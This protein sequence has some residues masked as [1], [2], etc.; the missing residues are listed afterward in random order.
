M[1]RLPTESLAKLGNASEDGQHLEQMEG[2][3]RRCR[4]ECLQM[5]PIVHHSNGNDFV[6]TSLPNGDYH[7]DVGIASNGKRN[8]AHIAIDHSLQQ[9]QKENIKEN[10]S[11]DHQTDGIKTND[12]PDHFRYEKLQL[13][14][15]KS[16]NRRQNYLYNL[17]EE[18]CDGKDY[19]D[20]MSMVTA[21]DFDSQTDIK[22]MP[23]PLCD[24]VSKSMNGHGHGHAKNESRKFLRRTRARSE[25]EHTE[26]YQVPNY[27]S[28]P[29]EVSAF[30]I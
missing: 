10:I 27:Q 21:N 19:Y 22:L 7:C 3:R 30:I 5:S 11:M 25:S 1:D 8:F 16:A 13:Y 24:E 17:S 20:L 28:N 29:S 6:K 23:K 2:M 26:F 15:D 12:F 9:Q 18:D 14:G 4:S